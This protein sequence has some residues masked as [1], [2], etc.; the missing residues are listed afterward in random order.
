MEVGNEFAYRQ[1]VR[2]AVL[3]DNGKGRVRRRGVECQQ[4]RNRNDDH[5]GAV[6]GHRG[7]SINF[8]RRGPN[9]GVFPRGTLK[10]ANTFPLS[11][12]FG[13]PLSVERARK[14]TRACCRE[15]R[16]GESALV[17]DQYERRYENMSDRTHLLLP[18]GGAVGYVSR[19]R[20]N[21]YSALQLCAMGSQ[22]L[23]ILQLE[24]AD[25]ECRIKTLPVRAI[26]HFPAKLFVE[27]HSTRGVQVK[28]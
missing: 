11:C 25:H 4:V 5:T 8:R 17:H 23:R 24:I 21:A 2:S 7:P 22:A 10:Y 15:R 26:Q 9:Q 1:D 14:L 13:T 19:R 20:R 28:P 3:A 6:I 16:I 18:I 27:A 12:R